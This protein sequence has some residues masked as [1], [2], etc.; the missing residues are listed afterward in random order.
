MTAHASSHSTST[1]TPSRFT[2]GVR[3]RSGSSCSC[4]SVL[5]FG[6]RKPLL[7][8]SAWSPRMRVTL[9]PV[10]GDL[11]AAAG[12][13]ERAGA[14][15]GARVVGVV[16]V[17]SP[18]VASSHQCAA[19]FPHAA[20][21]PH[22]ARVLRR[23]PAEAGRI[24]RGWRCAWWPA[25]TARPWSGGTSRF[26]SNPVDQELLL[27][28]RTLVDVVRGGRRHRAQGGL[29]AA[30]H[31]EPAPGR[32]VAL[33]RLRLRRAHLAVR[34]LAAHPARGRPRGAGAVASAPAS[35]TSTSPPRSPSSTP[36][37]CR[38]RVAPR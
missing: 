20:D 5:P 31:A 7:N 32:G 11:Q 8:T 37:W 33:G 21:R 16:R 38:P 9:P 18:W 2:S 25:S 29:R 24:G 13:A 10:D 3:S 4:F 14:E 27:T 28:L 12:L 22:A 15:G 1:C 35:A 26:L 36:T 34:P 30:A 17:R 6:Q 23:A 19:C